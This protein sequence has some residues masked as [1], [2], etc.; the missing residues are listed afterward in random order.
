MLPIALLSAPAVA[1]TYKCQDAAGKIIYQQ[2]P[3]PNTHQEQDLHIR[4]TTPSAPS[5]GLRP[6]EVELYKN[7]KQ[8]ERFNL[9]IRRGKIVLGMSKSDVRRSWGDPTDINRT[10][11]E[12]GTHEQWVYRGRGVDTQ[13]VHFD[14]DVVTSIG[15]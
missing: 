2:T 6:D 14:A 8:R 4:D 11:R 7:I 15:D 13:Y 10:I 5:T 3:C 12:S 9:L 1:A